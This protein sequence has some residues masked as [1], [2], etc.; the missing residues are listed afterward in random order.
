MVTLRLATLLATAAILLSPAHAE[1]QGCPYSYKVCGWDLIKS[2][3]FSFFLF[4]PTF[5][6][7]FIPNPSFPC[8]PFKC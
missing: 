3:S 5:L 4:L 8:F 6:F 1:I 7:F 2:G